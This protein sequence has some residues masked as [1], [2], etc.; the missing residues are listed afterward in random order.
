MDTR[1]STPCS[2]HHDVNDFPLPMSDETMSNEDLKELHD[3]NGVI[4]LKTT[5]KGS[6]V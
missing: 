2:S 6:K 1:D 5:Q 3:E 4:N